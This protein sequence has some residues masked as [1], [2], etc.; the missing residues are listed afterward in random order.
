M[1]VNTI[2]MLSKKFTYLQI[3]PEKL[4]NAINRKSTYEMGYLQETNEV[5]ALTIMCS[6][7]TDFKKIMHINL[8]KLII[9]FFCE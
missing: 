2:F 1:H 4:S 9:D 5:Q 7:T 6:D 3:L 8:L